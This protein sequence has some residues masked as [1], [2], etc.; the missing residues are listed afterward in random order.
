MNINT[1]K[2]LGWLDEAA[3]WSLYALMAAIP[4]SNALVSIF[5]VL[6]I[7]FFLFHWMLKKKFGGL[8]SETGGRGFLLL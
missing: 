2:I 5:S 3:R 1:V 4:F 6:T 8:F 7:A